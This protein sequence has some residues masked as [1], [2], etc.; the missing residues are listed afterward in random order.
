MTLNISNV[1]TVNG[2]KYRDL[3]EDF[4]DDMHNDI[5]YE[6]LTPHCGWKAVEGIPTCTKACDTK[7]RLCQDFLDEID[8]EY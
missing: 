1:H 4:E 6:V 3:Y 5:G 2:H 7:C 8:V